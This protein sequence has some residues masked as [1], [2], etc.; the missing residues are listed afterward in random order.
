MVEILISFHLNCS[1]NDFG[2][3]FQRDEVS[4]SFLLSHP[5]ALSCIATVHNALHIR[6]VHQLLQ[7]AKLLFGGR[8]HQI[9]PLLRQDGQVCNAPL[10]VLGIVD[11]GRC[12]LHQMPDA[13]A[14]QI[15][16]ALQITVLTVGR[17]EDFGVGHGNRR[18]FRHD[19]FC[20]KNPSNLFWIAICKAANAALKSDRFGIFFACLLRF[21]LGGNLKIALV[22]GVVCIGV[23]GFFFCLLFLLLLHKGVNAAA[24]NQTDQC[25]YA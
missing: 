11:I 21:V 17:T 19:Q 10:D 4:F 6:A 15:A 12:Q 7:D 22:L 23:K 25:Q 3:D 9:L 8:R 5:T 16:V 24:S 1:L 2:F 13:P 20:D 18:L 14:H